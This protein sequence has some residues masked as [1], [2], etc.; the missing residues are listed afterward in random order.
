MELSHD[1]PR[2]ER[3]PREKIETL[4]NIGCDCVRFGTATLCQR[5]A[6]SGATVWLQCDNCGKA[7]SSAFP[8]G[9]HPEYKRYKKWDGNLSDVFYAKKKLDWISGQEDRRSEYAEFLASDEWKALRARVMQ[10]AE[11][12]CEACLN[13]D[14]VAVHHVDYESGWLPP[15]W[16]LRAVCHACHDGIHGAT[17]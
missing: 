11:G 15:A 9:H 12:Q 13:A 10:R 2:M 4:L 17:P 7:L 1:F 5:E 8:R 6:A 3:F 16:K 14:A